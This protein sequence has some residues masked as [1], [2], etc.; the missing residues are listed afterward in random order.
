M[1]LSP[2]FL[3]GSGSVRDRSNSVD[4]PPFR[5]LLVA[6]RF[7][8]RGSS[9]YTLRLA[10]SL[11]QF[12]IDAR[13]VCTFADRVDV[14]RKKR[15]HIQEFP[16]LKLPLLGRLTRIQVQRD[17]SGW[18][19][20]LVHVQ[21]RDMM[22]VGTWLSGRFECPSILTVHEILTPGQRLSFSWK[23]IQRM[24][25]VSEPVKSELLKRISFDEK[26][27]A[28]I[29][30]GVAPDCGRTLPPV[31]DPGHLP[32]IGVAGPLETVKGILYFLGAAHRVLQSR[33]DVRFLI[34]GS[35]PEERN[36]RR[37]SRELG[38]S[39]KVTFV[40]SLTDFAEPL[41]AMDIY[42]LPSLEQGLGTIML[43][44]M[45]MGKPV[46]T[47]GVGGMAS[48]ICDNETGLVV[49]PASSGKLAGR[50]L[51]MLGDPVRARSL[52]EAGRRLVHTKFN[53]EAMLRKTVDLYKQVIA[54]AERPAVKA[55]KSA[56]AV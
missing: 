31:L 51:E 23:R 33:S 56:T 42:C 41:A 45:A 11:G 49:P 28:V 35:G 32:V 52:G 19:P 8:V 39:D 13:V 50:M 10:E 46:I 34:S 29:H 38:I 43:E 27:T 53:A 44:A 21:T 5:V 47:S 1:R 2:T 22:S 24:I 37:L 40:P 55:N 6:G 26:K 14:S 20:Q 48:V 12:G 9:L 7:E 4:E 54:E 18:I 30:C 3:P 17:L 16:Y 36:L 15:L 25:A